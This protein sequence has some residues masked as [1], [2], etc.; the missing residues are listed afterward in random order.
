MHWMHSD[1]V[2]PRALR[3]TISILILHYKTEIMY[4]HATTP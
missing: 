2:A 3:S 1:A 4:A